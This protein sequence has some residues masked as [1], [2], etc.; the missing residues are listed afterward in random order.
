MFSHATIGTNDMPR[1]VAFYDAV[2]ACLEIERF[3]LADDYAGYGNAHSDQVW[4]MKPFD[5]KPATVGNGTHIAFLAESR[6]QVDA[7]HKAALAHG[8]TDEGA[9]G[10]RQHYHPNYYGAYVRDPDGN[11][12]QAVC[13]KPPVESSG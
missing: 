13:H 7:F 8:G 1:A 3:H 6:D 2:F 4:V 11:K 10:L 9:P 5:G 12:I